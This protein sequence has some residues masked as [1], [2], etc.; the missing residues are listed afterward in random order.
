MALPWT[1]CIGVSALTQH[2]VIVGKLL[3]FSEPQ[4]AHLQN[5]DNSSTVSASKGWKIQ[6]RSWVERALHSADPGNLPMWL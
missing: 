6:K 4:F 1:D 5:G 3:Y 2:F